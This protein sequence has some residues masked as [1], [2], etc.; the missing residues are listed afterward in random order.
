[1]AT[2]ILLHGRHVHSVFELL[3]AKEN[4]LTY[5]IGWALSQCPTF[6]STLIDAVFPDEPGLAIDRVALQERASTAGVTDIELIGPRAHVIVEAKRGWEVPR[7]EQ[8]RLYAPRLRQDVRKA[9]VVMSECSPEF[10]AI[11]LAPNIDNVRVAHLGWREIAGFARLKHCKPSERL[12]LAQ[13]RLYLE[14]IVKMQN[15]DSNLVYVVSLGR[16]RPPWSTMTWTQIVEERSCYFHPIGIDGWPKEPP[17]YLGFRY[18][19]RLQRISHVENWKVFTEL[20]SELPGLGNPGLWEPHFL[21]TLGPAIVP[22]RLVKNG[23]IYP[24]G[25]V[26]AMLDLLLT[27]DTVAEARD[28]TKLRRSEDE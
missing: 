8:L 2:E 27:C 17:N 26:W 23:N 19:G 20:H 25:R 18:D 4:D 5:S 12:L 13:L 24:N 7:Q 28:R 9:I 15:Q 1:M 10:A 22:P 14:R 6:R 11:H 3:G 21:Y 16:D